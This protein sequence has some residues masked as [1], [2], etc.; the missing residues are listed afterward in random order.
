MAHKK[1]NQEQ[2]KQFKQIFQDGW[3]EFK[4]KYPRYEAVEE[5][6]EK[7]LGCG[8]LENGYAEYLCPECLSR[9]QVA[10]SCKSSFCLSC[11]KTYTANW[12]E[13]VQGMLH[14]GVKYRHLVLTVPE[15]LR[16]WF[17]R[18]PERL[19]D[20][21]LKIA[22]PMM[23]DAVSY[24]KRRKIELGYMV[25]LQ[26]AGRAANYNPHLHIIMTAGGLDEGEKWQELSYIR[27][28]IIHKKWQYYLFGMVKEV[29]S[30]RAEVGQLID[31][32]W[33]RYPKGLVAHLKE[34]AVPKVDKLA[35][36]I[37]KYVV[38]P[39]IALSRIIDYD[40]QQGT[41]KYWYEDHRLGRQEVEMNRTQFIGR[42][43][44]HIL[45]KGFKR[46]RY[47]GLQA[48]CKLKKVAT[49]LRGALSKA[50]QGVMDF[51]VNKSRSAVVRLRYRTR[52]NRAYGQDPLRCKQ[53]G[54]QMWLWQVWHPEYGVIYDE[55]EAL[56][57]GK[58]EPP[59]EPEPPAIIVTSEPVSQPSL[60]DLQAS[61]TYA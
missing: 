41:V 49:I 56:K 25:V 35:H 17:Y 21:L 58:Y 40:R 36:Y 18:Y 9:K 32:L 13:T 1:G 54:T 26:T 20:Q 60:F 27:Y 57:A 39:P 45:P 44:Q 4:A 22:A 38:S 14:E 24:A 29:L 8:E 15:D 50:V 59:L 28:E 7:M 10:F 23:D 51:V 5:V 53:C 46:V 37:A 11:A 55:G 61:L 34:K 52:L 43:V 16:V 12:V 48:T 3:Q 33:Q 42:L 6:I 2:K 19:Y 31:E 30:D 47:Y